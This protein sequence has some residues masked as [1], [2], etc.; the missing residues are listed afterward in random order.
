MGA[1]GAA[2]AV[3]VPFV[4]GWYGRSDAAALAVVASHPTMLTVSI[5]CLTMGRP[6][7]WG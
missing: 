4:V 5:A 1:A 3:G 2:F 6:W 7:S